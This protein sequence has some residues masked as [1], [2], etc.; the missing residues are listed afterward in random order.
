[1][2]IDLEKLNVPL[3]TVVMV[4]IYISSLVG[5]YYTMKFKV[6]DNQAKV[7]ELENK[8]SKYNPEVMDYRLN[9]LTKEVSKLNEKADKI[10]D[11]I[12]AK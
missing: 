10:Y 6:D 11:I 3:K 12:T 2:A 4:V 5:I 8:L 1:M 7:I 9:E